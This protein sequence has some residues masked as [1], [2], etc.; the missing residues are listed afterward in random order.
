MSLKMVIMVLWLIGELVYPSP[1]VTQVKPLSHWG[2]LLSFEV[3]L[4]LPIIIQSFEHCGTKKTD[5]HQ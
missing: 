2:T 4:H 1:E 5:V 3:D